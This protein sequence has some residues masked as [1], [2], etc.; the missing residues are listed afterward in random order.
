MTN[1]LKPFRIWLRIR[2]DIRKTMNFHRGVQDTAKI[3]TT[4]SKDI[5][6]RL[7]RHLH[8][9]SLWIQWTRAL[10]DGGK[11]FTVRQV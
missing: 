9:V 2:Q 11:R 6:A 5:S 10:F 8:G 7:T 3:T 4:K 1:G